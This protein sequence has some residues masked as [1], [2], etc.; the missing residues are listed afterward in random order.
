MADP[1]PFLTARWEHLVMLNWAAPR[2]LLEPLVPAGTT[3][4]DWHG[5]TLVSLVGFSFLDTRL[6]GIAV[7][8]H[9]DFEEVN[10]RFYVSRVGPDGDV[11]RAVVFIREIVPRAA[12]ALIARLAYNEPYITASMSR[13]VECDDQTGGQIA[14][15]WT[16]RRADFRISAEVD[17]PAQ[18]ML[19]GSEAAFVAEHYWGYTRQRDGGTLEYRVEHPP[20]R[21]WSPTRAAFE[22]DARQLY[23]DAFGEL[24]A[25]PP[26]SAVV[27]RGSEV[28]VY[29]GVR[30]Y[31]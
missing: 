14:Y 18:P 31:S 28:S 24:I 29:A 7:P 16:R 13:R 19:A 1:R 6:R 11:R 26:S 5:E 20:W 4:D 10:L 25:S 3:L 9:R 12:V 30:V 2:A 8:G 21:A 22:G 15:A 23:G 27:A 17:G